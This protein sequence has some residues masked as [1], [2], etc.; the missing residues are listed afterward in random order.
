SY[1][2][3]NLLQ[4]LRAGLRNKC[5][6]SETDS[7]AEVARSL[8]QDRVSPFSIGVYRRRIP[9]HG[10]HGGELKRGRR[11][12]PGEALTRISEVLANRGFLDAVHRPASG[13]H[14]EYLR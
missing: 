10:G 6:R 2:G 13:I 1:V 14:A 4:Q 8:I 3:T 12:H 11:T 5:G 7:A 9:V